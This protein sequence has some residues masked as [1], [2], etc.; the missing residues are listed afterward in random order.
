MLTSELREESGSRCE[1]RSN[2]SQQADESIS[3]P[4]SSMR[5]CSVS[6]SD[7]NTVDNADEDEHR[8]VIERRRHKHRRCRSHHRHRRGISSSAATRS[9]WVSCYTFIRSL[10]SDA[11]AGSRG[12][13]V[14]S[15][16]CLS[17]VANWNWLYWRAGFRCHK[18][19]SCWR[20]M[21]KTYP[22]KGG[23]EQGDH[24][25]GKPGNIGIWQLSG[26]CQG[27]VVE[28]ILSGKSCLKLFMVNCIF[29][30]VQVFSRNLLCFKC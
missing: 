10:V 15:Y 20:F 23:Q 8:R 5:Q 14:L 27:F 16:R 24:L 11:L 2:Y 9:T 25:S 28:K 29:V 1:Q 4:T 26:K 12:I 7:D 17:A 6:P 3:R 13:L 18:G 19:L 22:T 30:S 21:W